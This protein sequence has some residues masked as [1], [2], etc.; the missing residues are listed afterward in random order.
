[1]RVISFDGTYC[2][3]FLY[4]RFFD[5]DPI[6][7]HV[8][9]QFLLHIICPFIHHDET[10]VHIYKG[11][12][13]L[14]FSPYP[15]FRLV[16]EEV[17]GAKMGGLIYH[18]YHCAPPKKHGVYLYPKINLKSFRTNGKIITSWPRIGDPKNIT[19]LRY[20][21]IDECVTIS[22]HLCAVRF[23]SFRV[24]STMGGRNPGVVFSC[25]PLWTL[26]SLCIPLSI[27][28]PL[29]NSRERFVAKFP[30]NLLYSLVDT[31]QAHSSAYSSSTT[32][33]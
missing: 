24:P 7:L 5:Y 29:N 9:F 16:F 25:H 18:L 17:A 26:R 30:A 13:S 11:P 21:S 33:T 14:Y 12:K 2:P 15:F 10:R 19:I 28:R 6:C 27:G 31:F 8:S 3:L 1:M 22:N 32:E 4:W 20:F 23:S